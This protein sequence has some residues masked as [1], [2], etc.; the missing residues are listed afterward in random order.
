MAVLCQAKTTR[1]TFPEGLSGLKTRQSLRDNAG[2]IPGLAQWVEEA[3]L[4]Q[5]ATEVAHAAW[6]WCGCGCGIGRLLQ[7]QLQF[8]P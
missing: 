7:L 4:P 8:D 6:M 1:M 2:G 3:V 5:A